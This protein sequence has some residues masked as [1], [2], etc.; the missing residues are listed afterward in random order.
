MSELTNQRFLF[1][2]KAVVGYLN[3]AS[4]SPQL[5][6]VAAAAKHALWWREEHSGMPIPAFFST[7]KTIKEEFA[8][9]I[10]CPEPERV[11]MIPAASY[12]VATAAKNVPLSKG[13]NVIVVEDQFPSNYYSWAV[14]CQEAGAEL[15]V[16]ARPEAGATDRWS[17]RV[18]AA[19]DQHTAAVAIANIHWADGAVF[20]LKA[21]RIRTDEVDAW[22][23]IDGTQSLGAY[24]FDVQDIRPDVLCTGGYKWLMGP[25]GCGYAYYGERMDNGS[26]IEENW[27]NRAG[28]EDFRNLVNYRD[29]Y[30]PLAGRYSVGEHSNFLMGPM[31]MTALQQV[32]AWGPENIQTYCAGLWSGIEP[33]LEKAGIQLPAER[34]H[35]LIGLRLPGS[36]DAIRLAAE[37]ERRGL[38]VSYRGDAVRVSPNCYNTPEELAELAAAILKA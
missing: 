36:I 6:S 7:V 29:D 17:D 19:V 33:L 37:F 10:N 13:Q 31:Q 4:R 12:G 1:P 21:I 9:L 28:S 23:V 11:A 8:K 3:G 38:F 20:D 14:K 34:A 15:R 27:I 5:K 16:V 24:P 18:L 25:Y 32:N 22:L 35:H 26:P 2:E 30:R